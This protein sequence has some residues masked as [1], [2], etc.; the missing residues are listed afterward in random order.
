MN[1]REERG[2]V[3]AATAKLTQ[4]GKVWLVPSQ[5]GNGTKYTVC[6]DD[7]CP[8]CNCRDHEDTG[9]PCKHI[10]AA[11]FVLKREQAK[12]GSL[13][14]TRTL[15][16]TEKKTYRQDWPMYN[17]AQTEEKRRFLVLLHDLCCKLPDPPQPGCGR[18]RTPMADMIFAACL[19]VFTGFSSRRFGTDLAEAREKG[20]VRS[21][22]HPV[23]VCSFLENKLLT[24]VLKELVTVTALPLQAVEQTFAPDSTG[25]STSRFVRWFD[26][27]YGCERSGR[28]WVKAHCMCGVKTHVVT[29]VE[30]LDRD[31]ADS[32]QFK[33]LVEKTAAHFT[34][35]EVPADKAYLSHDNLELVG[36]LGATPFIP[37]KIN[38]VVGTTGGMWEKMFG[39]F[40]YR[41]DDFMARYHKRSNAESVF[42]MVKAK[43][44][45]AVRSKAETAMRNEVLAK[46]VCH[47]ICCVIMAQVELG[48]EPIFWTDAEPAPVVPDAGP[49]A[50]GPVIESV[51]VREAAP[52]TAQRKSAPIYPTYSF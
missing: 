29:A 39:Y 52:V 4:K 18:R 36:G 40:Q 8:F 3:I 30:I 10:F 17:L 32:P 22:L 15:T 23:A 7:E 1:P 37:F 31:A 11:R 35:K 14:E 49:V 48:I 2:L 27:K 13:V 28:D 33:P 44:G 26:E 51:A 46:L 24:A 47:N 25:F 42:S 6:P 20:Y 43:F 9:L 38:S 5:T 45:D 21:K 19:K 12:D 16:L 41:R 50:N 34:V